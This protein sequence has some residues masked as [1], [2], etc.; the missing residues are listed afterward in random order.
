MAKY[1]QN[2]QKVAETWAKSA[3]MGNSG[4]E[5]LKATKSGQK[6]QNGL[7]VANMGKVGQKQ[8]GKEVDKG[9]K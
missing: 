8:V 7:K 1:G 3:K 4:Q 6:C 9:G 2:S 5:L